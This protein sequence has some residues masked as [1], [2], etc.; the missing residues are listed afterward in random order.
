[1]TSRASTS[2]SVTVA[3][4]FATSAARLRFGRR[5]VTSP[6]RNASTTRRA[7]RPDAAGATIVSRPSGFQPA[8]LL[9]NVAPSC[10]SRSWFARYSTS[11]SGGRNAKSS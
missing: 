10:S 4:S 5:S 7:R 8:G 2:V 9:N 6:A 3:G 1:L 11:T